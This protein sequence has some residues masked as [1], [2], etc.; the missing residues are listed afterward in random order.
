VCA[1]IRSKSAGF[2]RRGGWH[3]LC[4]RRFESETGGAL[5]AFS[6]QDSGR[7]IQDN[8]MVVQDREL[9]VQDRELVVQD[10]E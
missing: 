2:W 4:C 10:R 9:V 6:E 1:P 3:G 7:L 5:V 8:G